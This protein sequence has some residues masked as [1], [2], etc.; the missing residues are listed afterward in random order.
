MS[1]R[2]RSMLPSIRDLTSPNMLFKALKSMSHS[3]LWKKGLRRR[4]WIPSPYPLSPCPLLTRDRRADRLAEDDLADVARLTK[5]EN[6]DRQPVVH[7]QGDRRGVHDLQLPF[8]HLEIG[9]RPVLRRL[10]VEHR[11]G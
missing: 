11:I 1:R 6:H 10:R 4:E 7:A 3:L 2:T 5:V 9:D 8:E